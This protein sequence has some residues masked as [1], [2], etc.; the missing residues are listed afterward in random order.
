MYDN[1]HTHT[2]THIVH[3]LHLSFVRRHPTGDEIHLNSRTF[4]LP[5]ELEEVLDLSAARL[6][7]VRDNLEFALR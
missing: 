6:S 1:A 3:S 4:I 5:G 2:Q 7:V